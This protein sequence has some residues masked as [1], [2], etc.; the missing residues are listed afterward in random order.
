MRKFAQ[1]LVTIAAWSLASFAVLPTAANAN[2]TNNANHL[3]MSAV[4]IAAAENPLWNGP[5]WIAQA[6]GI[7]KRNGLSVSFLNSPNASASSLVAGLVSGGYQFISSNPFAVP[8]AIQQG[9]AIRSIMTPY[10][11]APDEI[12]ISQAAAAAHNIPASGSVIAQ[13]SAL[14]SSHLSICYTTPTAGT[15][16]DLITVLQKHG[17]TV[18]PSGDIVGDQL[19][20]TNTCITALNSGKVDGLVNVPPYTVQPNTVV[21]PFGNVTPVA[22][23][24]ANPISTTLAMIKQHPDTVQAFV[25]S[26]VEGWVYL[27]QHPSQ[28]LR[29]SMN[30]SASVV[31]ITSPE[32]VSYLF[33]LGLTHRLPTPAIT[34]TD[35]AAVKTVNNLASG[36]PITLSY[37][38][39]I[40]STFVNRAITQLNLHIP[41]A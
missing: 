18:G 38:Q 37:G 39:W 23:E 31:G 14:K 30:Y 25:T 21:I 15:Y 32:E 36:T 33:Q 3:S 29:I 9:A 19:G 13:I 40:D 12:A 28:A 35:F 24:P 2:Q 41:K 11:G 1:I 26:M 22:N 7:F 20:S 6:T 34:K 10:T 5:M 16:L 17:L 8:A 4:T 27:G